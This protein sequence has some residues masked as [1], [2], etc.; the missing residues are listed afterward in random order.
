MKGAALPGNAGANIWF[1]YSAEIARE[2][3][4]KILSAVSEYFNSTYKSLLKYTLILQ[5]TNSIAETT[6]EAPQH[7]AKKCKIAVMS[8]GVKQ[9]A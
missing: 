1:G 5:I 3:Q 7:R 2:R 4:D 8:K 6:T 9:G